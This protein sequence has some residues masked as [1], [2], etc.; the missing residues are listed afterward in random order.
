[1]K[2]Y[3]GTEYLK[4]LA[5]ACDNIYEFLKSIDYNEVWVDNYASDFITK[6]L[7]LGGVDVSECYNEVKCYAI[8]RYL[9]QVWNDVKGC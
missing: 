9:I 3:K 8:E 4:E 7:T 5:I 1:M 2:Y 6:N